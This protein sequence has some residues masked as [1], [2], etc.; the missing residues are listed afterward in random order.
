[1]VS[2]C[3]PISRAASAIA[4]SALGD[5]RLIAFGL[6]K[7]DQLDIVDRSRSAVSGSDLSSRWRSRISIAR[8]CRIV[9]EIG[10]SAL[11]V[12]FV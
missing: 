12:E 8:V 4:A 5:E 1:M 11:G 10:A 7:L 9:P 6:A 3:S 2:S